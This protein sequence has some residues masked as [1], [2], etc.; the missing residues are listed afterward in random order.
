M[1]IRP[2]SY[3]RGFC[4][5]IYGNLLYVTLDA[6]RNENR[7]NARIKHVPTNSK[8][9]NQNRELTPKSRKGISEI[10]CYPE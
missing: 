8:F 1:I 2:F 4:F 3:R 5:D 10:I 6:Q 9:S 7:E